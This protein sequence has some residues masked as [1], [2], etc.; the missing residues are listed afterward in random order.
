[1]K[2]LVDKEYLEKDTSKE[3]LSRELIIFL[4]LIPGI[5]HEINNSLTSTMASTELLQK[6]ITKIRKE[7]NENKINLN[8][9]NHIEK[10]STI[11]INNTIKSQNIL[12]AIL[13]E[14]IN[15]LK[16]QCSKNNLENSRFDH[17]DKLL[18]LNMKSA[19]KIELI[20]KA[21]RK[22]VSF[23]EEQTLVDVNEVVN[24]SMI[25]SQKQLKNKYT[26]KEDFNDLPLVNFDFH[27]LN[28]II[29]CILLKILELTTSGELHFKTYEDEKDVHITIQLIGGEFSKDNLNFKINQNTSDSKIDLASIDRLL[30]HK[31][32]ALDIINTPE[33]ENLDFKNDI[34][35]GISFD[36]KLEKNNLESSNLE[37]NFISKNSNEIFPNEDE[38]NDFYSPVISDEDIKLGSKNVLIVDDNPQTLVSLFLK[39]KNECL[40]NNVIIAKTAESAL[41]KI[42]ETNFDIVIADYRLPGMDGIT[43]LS[44]V[45]ERCPSTT[46]VLITAFSNNDIKE[47]ANNKASVKLLIEKPFGR[48][49]LK[50]LIHEIA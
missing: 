34:S 36:I 13:K 22:I 50:D 26:I 45:K 3:E 49:C 27:K 5:I 4:D 29:I 38:T 21:F 24:T 32:G 39:I 47:E 40:I 16:D 2:P 42:E 46:R 6:E 10:L 48:D 14:E 41:E 30:Q 43:F 12:T 25:I 33:K 9:I 7:T 17:L 37:N 31:N 19:R 15:R 1:M 18:T 44:K 28:Y 20:V 8:L 11:N 35:G 23:D